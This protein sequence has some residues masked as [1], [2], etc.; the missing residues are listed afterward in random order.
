MSSAAAKRGT[1]IGL[2]AVVAATLVAFGLT[3]GDAGA[4]VADRGVEPTPVQTAVVSWEDGYVRSRTYVG[5]VE[6]HRESEVAFEVGGT[7]DAVLVDEGDAVSAGATMARLDTDRR[8]AARD[9]A[10]ARL[11]SAEARLAELVAGPRREVVAAASADVERLKADLELARIVEARQE[12]IFRGSAGTR[13]S[14]DN[15][16][17]G[18]EAAMAAL[19]ASQS[20]LTELN[21]GTRKEEVDA[22]RAAVAQAR[23]EL[24]AADSDIAKSALT[25]PFAGR[26]AGR[27]ADEGEV[28]AA[29]AA[30]FV[31]METGRMEVRVG[32]GPAVAE[33]LAPGDAVTARVRGR[34]LPARVRSLR[35]DRNGATRSVPVLLSLESDGLF[36]GDLAE[37]SFE[38][39]VDEAN[40]AVPV[41]ALVEGVR[42]LWT[43]FVVANRDHRTVADP[44]SVQIVHVDG[45]RVRVTGPLEEGE[46]I[47]SA[48]VHRVVAGQEVT[49]DGP[50]A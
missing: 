23:A 28:V 26:V 33:R 25:A 30:A 8:T 38:R 20:R 35:P 32:V 48:G 50:D 17:L 43:V 16:R 27:M 31:L 36:A 9:A 24:A 42:G 40:F 5:R 21:N 44:R 12:K 2:A 22:Q 29:G 13:Q 19:Q 37:V 34:D 18:A 4:A 1:A 49:D 7:V 45:D 15:A 46:R 3:R 11:A 41:A 14:F 47:V 39:S 10:A 6:A